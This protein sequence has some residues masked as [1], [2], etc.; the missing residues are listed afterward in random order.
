MKK[1]RK[2]VEEQL[3]QLGFKQI[4]ITDVIMYPDRN[5]TSY[6]RKEEKPSEK[7]IN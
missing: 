7:H 3:K 5:K 4:T 2:T 6:K 1:K